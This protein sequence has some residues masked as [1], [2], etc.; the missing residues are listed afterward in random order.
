MLAAVAGP[1]R[2]NGSSGEQA[3]RIAPFEELELNVAELFP[4]RT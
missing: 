2:P 4:P 3:A 1:P